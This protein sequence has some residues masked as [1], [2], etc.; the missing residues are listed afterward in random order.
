MRRTEWGTTY[1]QRSNWHKPLYRSTLSK[2]MLVIEAWEWNGYKRSFYCGGIFLLLF[3]PSRSYLLLTT[4]KSRR[5][6]KKFHNAPS[7]QE[8]SCPLSG[9]PE[10]EYYSSHIRYGILSSIVYSKPACV[11][12]IWEIQEMYHRFDGILSKQPLFQA[13]IPLI[14]LISRRGSLV[15]YFRVI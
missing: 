12:Q 7:L 14:N 15:V 8:R 13:N 10:R 6:K 9:Q 4:Q 2:N 3:S 1:L 11:D 5:A